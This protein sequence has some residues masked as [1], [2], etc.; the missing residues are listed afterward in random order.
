MQIQKAA[1][2]DQPAEEEAEPTDHLR[3]L[4]GIVSDAW[5]KRVNEAP[6]TEEK[7]EEISRRS[8]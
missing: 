3:D 1:P 2:Q 6:M 7:A 4:V 5:A 8:T